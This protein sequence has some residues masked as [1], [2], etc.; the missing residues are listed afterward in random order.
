MMHLSILLKFYKR[1]DVQKAIVKHA[2]DKEIAVK[3]NDSG[4]GK[5]PDTLQHPSD[6]LELVRKG[7]SSFHCSEELWENPMSLDLNMNQKDLEEL[8]KGWDLILDIDCKI[9]EYSK[10]AADLIVRALRH[11]GISSLSVKFSGNHGFHIGIPFETFP[12]RVHSTATKNLFPDGPR[13]IAGLLKTMIKEPLAERILK[14]HPINIIAEKTGKNAVEL[15]DK[16]TFN[17]FAILEIDTI[18]ISHRHLYRM[19]YCFNEK[20]GLVSIPVN[21]DKILEFDKM[22]AV[23]GNVEIADFV[24]L[25]RQKAHPDEARKLIV[26][27]FDSD[28]DI[29][30][31]FKENKKAYKQTEFETPQIALSEDYFPPCIRKILQGLD[32][33]KK[34][35]LFVMVNFLTSTGWDYDA[36]EK[37]IKEWNKK[38]KEE[39][40]EVL[41]KGQLTYHKKHRK[42]I[43]PPN[44][45]NKQYY[46]DMRICSP[47]ALCKK[48]KNPVNYAIIKAKRRNFNS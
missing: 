4:F 42:S 33:G 44:C 11:F 32:D 15:K 14:L 48:I 31:D 18:L 37:L 21:P 8:R 46:L 24:F 30:A 5:R 10:I 29:T 26:Q 28:V 1:E 17:P 3:F 45:S 9:L 6:V 36:V 39:L 22:M 34:R 41:I 23:P 47:D 12:R 7:A 19:P 35:S 40:R 27:A 20:S 16:E 25:D 38:N 2:Q 13:K 43:L